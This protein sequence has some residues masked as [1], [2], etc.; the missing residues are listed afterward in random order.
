MADLHSQ[1]LSNGGA[2]VGSRT[3]DDSCRELPNDRPN[4]QFH[5]S[6]TI[7]AAD[8][9]TM[10]PTVVGTRRRQRQ[11][12][13]WV[14]RHPIRIFILLLLLLCFLLAFA[15][16]FLLRQRSNQKLARKCSWLR[17]RPLVCAHGGDTSIAP[18][19]TL[20]AYDR[21]LIAKADC[22]EIDA[23]RSQDG[24]LVALHD[25]DLQNIYGNDYIRVR[26]LSLKEIVRLD[27][28]QNF[29]KKFRNQ[30]V[31]TLVNAI[32]HVSSYVKQ[33]IIDAK[34]GGP[35][36]VGS[37]VAGILDAVNVTRC[38]NCLV[39]SKDDSLVKELKRL[40]PR[41]YAG[42]IV[43]ED[44]VT[45]KMTSST[46]MNTPEV[47]GAYHGAISAK[48]VKTIHQFGKTV[49]AWTV[50]DR[51]RMREMLYDGVDAIVTS[52][53]RLLQELMLQIQNECFQEGFHL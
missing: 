48:F 19:N 51:E 18:P 23:S 38:S 47:V 40:S 5:V 29:P 46:R 6:F 4:L 20:E 50:N 49:Y 26:D 25:R 30:T 16:A 41:T 44:E 52:Q 24:V 39:W 3:P 28:G 37:I 8:K 34:V 21:A 15:P 36:F 17:N 35:V 33:I 2:S 27:A 22:I 7:R 1:L 11:Q 9:K 13:S 53:P 31:P 42:Y 32:Q 12:R 10:L 43:M 14:R 45:G